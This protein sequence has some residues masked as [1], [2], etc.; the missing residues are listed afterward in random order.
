MLVNSEGLVPTHMV[1][2]NYRANYRMFTNKQLRPQCV[3][4][5][6]HSEVTS[7]H[8]IYCILQSFEVDKFYRFRGSIG[9]CKTSP[10]KHYHLS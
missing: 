1:N 10:V 5:I 6:S 7:C 4:V 2:L 9:K 8:S 3:Y